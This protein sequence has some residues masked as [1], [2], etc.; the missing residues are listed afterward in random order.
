MR[1]HVMTPV[2]E[3]PLWWFA[4]LEASIERGDY[5]SAAE[6]LRE[7]ERL[8]VTVKYRGRQPQTSSTGQEVRSAS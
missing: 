4:R 1:S 3:W 6:A 5:H 8:G 7:L 2:A